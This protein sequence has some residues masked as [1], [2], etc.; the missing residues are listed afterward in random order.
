MAKLRLAAQAAGADARALAQI[1]EC[2]T[3]PGNEAVADVVALA[4]CG[5]REAVAVFRWECLS[6]C[7][8]RCRLSLPAARLPAP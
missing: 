2:G 8:R 5:E 4:D 3:V 1:G 6:R 7:G